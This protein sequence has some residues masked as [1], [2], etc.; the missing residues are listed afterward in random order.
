MSAELEQ[1]LTALGDALEV[2]PAPDLVPVTLERLQRIA[3]PR[4]VTTRRAFAV[5]V[6]VA[7]VLAG[8]A[9]A[10]PVTRNAVLD[11]LG[12]RG[13][14]IERVRRLPPAEPSSSA[15]TRLQLGQP[16]G[17][18]Q[19]R[20]AAQFTA[21]L[22]STPVRAYLAHDV[23]GG[24]IS[25]ILGRMLIIEFRGAASPFI[26]KLVGEGTKITRVRV[27]GGRGFYL[28]GAV[29]QVL[30]QTSTGEVRA[31][32]VRLAGNVL[33]WQQGPLTIRIEGT[34]SLPEAV[35]VARSLR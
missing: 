1:R 18:A 17:L 11:V 25:L 28:S 31:D 15:G 33:I 12:L 9:M 32:T 27:N 13:V 24:R 7:L 19:A 30:F 6:A 5:A 2:P 22:P 35:A 34:H 29:H 26:F 21:V 8:A 3:R 23:P 10:I 4:R 14:R 20:H 16:I